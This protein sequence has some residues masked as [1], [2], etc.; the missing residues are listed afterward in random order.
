MVRRTPAGRSTSP[1]SPMLDRAAIGALLGAR[2]RA[3]A[4]RP[5][6]RGAAALSYR[7]R[8]Q[9][10]EPG[11]ARHGARRAADGHRRGRARSSAGSR[12]ATA[13][14]ALLDLLDGIR[15]GA[16]IDTPPLEPGG[17]GPARVRE[18][19]ERRG[20]ADRLRS[21][22]GPGRV[23]PRG[24]VVVGAVVGA[25]SVAV[26]WSVVVVPVLV[27]AAAGVVVWCP[28]GWWSCQCPASSSCV[29]ASCPGRRRTSY[30]RRP[31]RSSRPT[32]SSPVVSATTAITKRDRG[33]GEPRHR[34]RSRPSRG[35]GGRLAVDAHWPAAVRAAA[36]SGSRGCADRRGGGAT[37]RV[38][39]RRASER[40][41]VAGPA[42]GRFARS[43]GAALA[44]QRHQTGV[45]AAAIH[46][47][48]IHSCEVTAAAD[49][50]RDARDRQRAR[51]EAA[52]L[53][54]LG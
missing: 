29:A 39:S 28:S 52:L 27:G 38:D 40:R 37:A 12:A 45:I 50:R 25:V 35:A 3:D 49:S 21:G 13:S 6:A 36:G 5:A 41:L 10:T 23:A 51:V 2:A 8:L 53:L 19:A 44:H 48:A 34:T 33:R 32:I 31:C 7:L 22:S 24:A 30:G 43:D 42:R 1:P 17:A 47:P 26:G 9:P 46:V 4:R 16:G 14:D 11:L 18:L 20:G 15:E 54:A